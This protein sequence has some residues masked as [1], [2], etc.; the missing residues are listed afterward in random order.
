M[1]SFFIA[2]FFLCT[3]FFI[4]FYAFS[5]RADKLKMSQCRFQADKCMNCLKKWQWIAFKIQLHPSKTF[6]YIFFPHKL[7]IWKAFF[8]LTLSHFDMAQDGYF[9]CQ[10]YLG[11]CVIVFFILL[12]CN[13]SLGKWVQRIFSIACS[14]IIS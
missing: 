9:S 5:I 11:H 6:V 1:G 2:F 13:F 14:V 3:I 4:H 7:L 8:L 12:I 10:I